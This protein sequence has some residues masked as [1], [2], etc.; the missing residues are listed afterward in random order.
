MQAQEQGFTWTLVAKGEEQTNRLAR[1][2]ASFVGPG[3]LVTLSGGLGVG[4]TTFARGLIRAIL[5]DPEIEVP[6]PTFTLLQAYEHDLFAI[7]HADLFRLQSR[8]ELEA[9]GWEE[10]SQDA[11]VLVEWPERAGVDT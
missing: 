11:L 1:H 10:M 5:R 6:S 9:L 3:D 7:I 4:K 8:A 2:L